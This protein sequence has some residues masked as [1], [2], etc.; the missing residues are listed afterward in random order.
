M[1]KIENRKGET[2]MENKTYDVYA[3]PYG[4]TKQHLV[5]HYE[6]KSDLSLIKVL[7][8]I[9][10]HDDNADFI[11]VRKPDSNQIMFM[12]IWSM[13]FTDEPAIGFVKEQSEDES[14]AEK[15]KI[16][17]RNPFY[18][19]DSGWDEVEHELIEQGRAWDI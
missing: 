17:I 7:E 14:C 4:K 6:P 11:T 8:H 9:L 15:T 10:L 13:D 19:E 3:G 1:M 2:K 18:D 5:A 16:E 12:D